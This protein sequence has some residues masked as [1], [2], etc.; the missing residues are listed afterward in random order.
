M[1][2]STNTRCTR[3]KACLLILIVALNVMAGCA[4]NRGITVNKGHDRQIRIILAEASGWKTEEVCNTLSFHVV[5]VDTDGQYQQIKTDL[6]CSEHDPD[7]YQQPDSLED[8][9]KNIK[10]HISPDFDEVMFIIHGGLV[11]FRQ[12]IQEAI[13]L[14]RAILNDAENNADRKV[15]PIFINWRS[16]GWDAYAEQLLEIRKGE[17]MKVLGKITAPVKLMSDI[18]RGIADMPSLGALEGDRLWDTQFHAGTLNACDQDTYKPA[19]VK[20]PDDA[21]ADKNQFLSTFGYFVATPVRI[22]TAPF[23]NGAGRPAWE[24]MVR[25]TRNAFWQEPR[26]HKPAKFGVVRALFDYLFINHRG[27]LTDRYQ[28]SAE[29]ACSLGQLKIDLIGHSMGTMI[30]SDLLHAYPQCPYND[31]VFMAAAVSLREANH[32]LPRVLEIN[33][34]VNFYN[35][36][37]LPKRDARELSAFGLVPSGSLLEWIDEMYTPPNT[38]FDRTMGKWV[39]VREVLPTISDELRKHMTFRVFGGSR[40]EPAEHGAFNNVDMCFWRRSFWEGDWTD[41][42]GKCNRYIQSIF[43]KVQEDARSP[44]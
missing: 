23:V 13:E 6:L 4:T 40:S 5:Q 18:G 7:P 32:S 15:Y 2:N 42:H 19:K 29:Q 8:H 37:L 12:G 1:L 9:L 16:G 10:N 38:K 11:S 26:D 24:N 33:S 17:R 41:H 30:V 28:T 22:L 21:N 14:N 27:E 31:I 39:N 20:C 43:P 34:D 35:L 3:H 36:S 44:L 25:R